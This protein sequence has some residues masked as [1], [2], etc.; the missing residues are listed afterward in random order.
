MIE[1]EARGIE[2]RDG[3]ALVQTQRTSACGHCA[4]K[5]G[6]GSLGGGRDARVWAD[7]W[8]GVE[9][10]DKVMVAVPETA[11]VKASLVAYLLPVAALLGGAV[12]GNRYGP[13]MGYDKDLA[14]AAV[15]IAAMAL[16]LW[17]ARFWAKRRISGPRI[18]K[19]VEDV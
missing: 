14:A 10:G 12:A 6:C 5:G 13:P 11:F 2:V 9:R 7:D 1:E 19:R 3:R 15:G 8:V 18:V 17:F 4:A 16:A